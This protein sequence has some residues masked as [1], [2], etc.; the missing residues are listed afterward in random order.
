MPKNL[1]NMQRNRPRVDT[2]VL[3]IP[4][5]RPQNLKNP[6][7][8]TPESQE[9]PRTPENRH[10]SLKIHKESLRIDSRI[11]RIPENRHQSLESLTESFSNAIPF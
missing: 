3:R 5:N 6:Q 7:E 1:L 11:S 2:R 4:K 10:Q 8:S 9:S